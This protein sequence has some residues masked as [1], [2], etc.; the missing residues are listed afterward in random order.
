MKN[1]YILW[2]EILRESKRTNELLEVRLPKPVEEVKIMPKFID[3]TYACSELH[4]GRTTFY[5]WVRGRL[6]HPAD[7]QGNSDYYDAEQVRNLYQ[8]HREERVP[9]RYMQPEEYVAD[10]A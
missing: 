3:T 5:A 2:E 6:L 4:I 10:A 8:R 7:R 1:M 9:Y